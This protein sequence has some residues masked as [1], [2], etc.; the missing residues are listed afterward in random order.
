MVL[1]QIHTND[2][3]H[4][5]WM[6]WKLTGIKAPNGFPQL[7]YTIYAI[8]INLFVTILFPLTLIMNLFYTDGLQ[9][10]CENLTITIT[11]TIANLKF[12]NVFFVR[13]KLLSIKDIVDKLDIRAQNEPGQRKVLQQ[14]V[15]TARATFK[16]FWG[17]YSFGTFLSLCKIAIANDRSL[18]YPAWFPLDWRNSMGQYTI[19]L[20]YQLFG[21]IVQAIQ[22]VANDSYP[23]AYLCILTGHLRALGLRVRKIGKNSNNLE[24]NYSK[25]IACI[26]D[27][28]IILELHVIIQGIIST[29]CLAQFICSGLVQCTVGI[30]VLFIM[31]KN[32][33]SALILSGIFF[34]AVTLESFLI[35]YF[36]H[37]LKQESED[38]TNAIYDCNWTNQLPKFKRTLV[39]FMMR[40]HRHNVIL[41]GNYIPVDFPTFLLIMK[42][43]YSVFTLLVRL[44]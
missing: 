36:G 39:F 43:S 28:Q 14:S 10:V 12:L 25:L 20:G 15:Q 3:F 26:K 5:H 6:V 1:P 35:C 17:L 44:K 7:P 41:A 37:N 8:S 38:L 42:Y 30:Y 19:V 23:A 27:H 9:E 29:A 21:L 18:L 31:G 40:T 34:L 24:A 33:I 2:A 4:Y 32:E 16:M 13:S 11:D 22:D